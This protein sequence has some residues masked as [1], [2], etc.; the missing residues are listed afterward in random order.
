MYLNDSVVDTAAAAACRI[1]PGFEAGTIHHSY[2]YNVIF[3]SFAPITQPEE[4]SAG[5]YSHTGCVVFQC[6][7]CNS[8][9]SVRRTKGRHIKDMTSDF[10]GRSTQQ[11]SLSAPKHFSF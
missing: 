3:F 4:E 10:R 6:C 8:A 7:W 5:D 9:M 1:Q 2:S 11:H